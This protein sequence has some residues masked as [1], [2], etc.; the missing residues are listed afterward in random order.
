MAAVH[1]PD[2]SSIERVVPEDVATM[3]NNDRAHGDDF[4]SRA[5][6]RPHA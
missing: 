2:R 6:S 4:S 5:C 3:F 1:A